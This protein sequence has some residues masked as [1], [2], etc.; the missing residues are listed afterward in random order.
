[1]VADTRYLVG[2][3]ALLAGYAIP[4]AG[5]LNERA[6]QL[7][8]DAKTLVYFADQHRVLAVL[9][10]T[11]QIK[12]GSKQAISTL[13]NK[14]IR[15]YMLTGDNQH[16]AKA[17]A[18]QVGLEDYK[19]ELLPDDKSKFVQELQNRGYIVA[20]VGDGIND[21]QA[22]AQAD[23]SIAMG[24]GSDIAIDVASMTL[25]GNDLNT[26]AKAFELSRQTVKTVK[27]NLFWAFIYNLTGIPLAAGVLYSFN[28]FLLDPMI[29]ALAMTL[30]SISVVLNSLR[31]KWQPLTGI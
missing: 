16:T 21:S 24:K 19:A 25:I 5:E 30:S 22:L 23:I 6:L 13:Q 18:S 20:M 31:L 8:A 12:P 28:G 4:L 11:D 14:G 9:A 15:V 17:V 3:K 10:I 7:Q 29:A 1:M 27:Q 26:I 2:N